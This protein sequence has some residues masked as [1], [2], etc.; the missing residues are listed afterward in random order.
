MKIG[1]TQQGYPRPFS[2]RASDAVAAQ[3]PLFDQDATADLAARDQA[4]NQLG[5]A[6]QQLANLQ[7]PGKPT[8]ITLAQANLAADQAARD[9]VADRPRP[10]Q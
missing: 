1:P 6:E 3:A 5:Q 10:R 4:E 8:E 9:K 2:A 7:A